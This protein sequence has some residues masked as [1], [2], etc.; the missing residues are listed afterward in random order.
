[1]GIQV[2]KIIVHS[3]FNKPHPVEHDIALIK[4][5][6]D[7]DSSGP[8]VGAACM[9]N[10]GED[11][12]GAEGCWLSGWGL[13]RPPRGMPNQLQKLQGKIWADA[14]GPLVCPS[15]TQPGQFNV[16]GVVSWGTGTCQGQ[17][18]VF[19]EVTH[20]L[21]WIKANMH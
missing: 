17:P 10:A 18:G 8:Y 3:L 7:V 16:I 6:T 4:L 5:A 1:M 21:P 20:F 19:T 14:G 15:K 9:P 13:V 12:H 11:Y 2:S